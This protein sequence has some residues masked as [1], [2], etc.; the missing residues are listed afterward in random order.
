MKDFLNK[1]DAVSSQHNKVTTVFSTDLQNRAKLE[2][3]LPFMYL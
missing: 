3:N 1:K 2:S